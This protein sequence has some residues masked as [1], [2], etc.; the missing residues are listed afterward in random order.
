MEPLFSC[1]SRRSGT[2]SRV[3]AANSVSHLGPQVCSAEI[4]HGWPRLSFSSRAQGSLWSRQRYDRGSSQ[5]PKALRKKTL[6]AC[7]S[8]RLARAVASLCGPGNNPSEQA[9]HARRALCRSSHGRGGFTYFTERASVAE[10]ATSAHSSRQ[11]SAAAAR[12]A[13]KCTTGCRRLSVCD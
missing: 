12:A 4:C 2:L 3:A 9:E 13:E 1:R 11:R 6:S 7:L 5:F 10:A 8:R